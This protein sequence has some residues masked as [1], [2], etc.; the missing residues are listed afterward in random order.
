MRFACL[1]YHL[2]GGAS[3]VNVYRTGDFFKAHSDTPHRSELDGE[4][5]FASLVILLPTPF[6]GGGLVVRH[7]GHEATLAGAPAPAPGLDAPPAA[8]AAG[9]ASEALL[10]WAAFYS[11]CEHEV[12]GAGR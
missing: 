11:D 8:A 10:R 7:G 9:G 6:E 4:R 5:A 2:T 3:Q 1:P 12:I